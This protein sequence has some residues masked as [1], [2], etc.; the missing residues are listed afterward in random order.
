MSSLIQEGL[1]LFND[2]IRISPG[3]HEDIIWLS[4]RYLYRRNNRDVKSWAKKT[5][6]LGI[7]VKN[8]TDLVAKIKVINQCG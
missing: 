3:K 1:V 2:G 6:S 8:T 4:T 5:V 7:I